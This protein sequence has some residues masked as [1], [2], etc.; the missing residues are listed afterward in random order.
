MN[1]AQIESCLG[2]SIGYSF[3]GYDQNCLDEGG[4]TVC[5][6][7]FMTLKFPNEFTFIGLL[8]YPY[9]FKSEVVDLEQRRRLIME[10]Y[11]DQQEKDEPNY[12]EF[13]MWEKLFLNF[14]ISNCLKHFA[15]NY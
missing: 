13:F 1:A 14:V 6:Q 11:F 12:T 10:W 9:D 4:V 5:R 2:N 3:T 7:L 15:N 8:Y